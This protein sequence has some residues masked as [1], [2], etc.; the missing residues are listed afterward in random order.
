MSSFIFHTDTSLS[1]SENPNLYVLSR[2]AVFK[3]FSIYKHLKNKKHCIFSILNSYLWLMFHFWGMGFYL[4]YLENGIW[5]VYF[6]SFNISV[7]L[8]FVLLY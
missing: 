7:Y 8:P 3:I 4:V 1:V 2:L 6:E 5:V